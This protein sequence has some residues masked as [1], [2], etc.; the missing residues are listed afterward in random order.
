MLD[1]LKSSF[2]NHPWIT[3]KRPMEARYVCSIYELKKNLKILRVRRSAWIEE[4]IEENDMIFDVLIF[5]PKK[6]EKRQNKRVKRSSV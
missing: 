6:K 5:A 2:K 4:L 3:V 1:L